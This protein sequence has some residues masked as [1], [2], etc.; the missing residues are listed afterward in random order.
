MRIANTRIPL[1]HGTPSVL[2][3]LAY[4]LVALGLMAGY[5][6]I[7]FPVA[8]GLVVQALG[9]ILYHATDD[10]AKWA[11]LMDA[12]GIQWAMSAIVAFALFKGGLLPLWVVYPLLPPVWAAW[13]LWADHVPSRVVAIGVQVAVVLGV[14]AAVA[15]WWEILILVGVFGGAVWLWWSDS[16]HSFAHSWWHIYTAAAQGMAVWIFF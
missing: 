13:W 6:L 14:A 8:V 4:F 1:Q 10:D 12:V 5:G 7:A 15:S 2:S 16:T 9:S 11:Q 3:N